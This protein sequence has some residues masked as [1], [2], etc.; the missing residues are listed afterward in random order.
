MNIPKELAQFG[1]RSPKAPPHR[2]MILGIEADTGSGKSRF[3]LETA[4]KPLLHINLD[5]NIEVME[6]R[7]EGQDILIC[8]VP[9]P[10]LIDKKKDLETFRRVEG[11]ITV[12][13]RKKFFRTVSI[14]TGDALWELC[15]RGHIGS[16]DFGGGKQQDFTEPNG[17][18]RGIYRAAKAQKAVSLIVS[19]RLT[20]ER[21]EAFSKS[22]AK[23]SI[24]TGRRIMSGWKGT[25]YEMQV[26]VRLEKL[27]DWEC[28]RDSCRK[29]C[30][31]PDLH[32]L[33]RFTCT[34]IKCTANERA[35]GEVLTGRDITFAN[36]GMLVFPATQDTPEVWEDGSLV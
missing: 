23:T 7:Y 8:D 17:D 31:K 29:G 36:I 26:H 22:G 18:M 3:V 33:D 1:L 11:L 2:R 19:H 30:T 6:E 27:K 5:D 34:I 4:P 14:D 20:D 24:Q 9:M 16:I 25:P 21:K 28:E 13:L 10:K 35:E 15:R 32:R 12:C